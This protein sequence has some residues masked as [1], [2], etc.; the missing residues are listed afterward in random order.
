MFPS[1]ARDSRKLSARTAAWRLSTDAWSRAFAAGTIPNSTTNDVTISARAPVR[2]RRHSIELTSPLTSIHRLSASLP[3]DLG[4]PQI[5][6]GGSPIRTPNSEA[7]GRESCDIVKS[8]A[9][10]LLTTNR[11]DLE[12]E[13]D[14]PTD[15]HVFSVIH[16]A[17]IPFQGSPLHVPWSRWIVRLQMMGRPRSWCCRRESAWERRRNAQ[18]ART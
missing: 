9:H 1:F 3:G 17:R 12:F 15:P 8:A 6:C 4:I 7:S 18:S 16:T 14:P 5:W 2:Y 10:P 13:P 11:S